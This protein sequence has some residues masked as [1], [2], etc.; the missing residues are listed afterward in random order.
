MEPRQQATLTY[1]ERARKAESA[2]AAE[3][4]FTTHK[5]RSAW[6]QAR[7][8]WP[9]REAPIDRLNLERARSVSELAP[10]P[11]AAQW[12]PVGPSDIGGRMTCA[13]C[14]PGAA[15]RLWAGAAGGGVWHSPDGGKTWQVLWDGEPSLNIG[16]L[17]LDPQS[18]DLIYCGTGEANLSADSHPGV[19]LF[20]SLNAGQ[21]WQVLAAADTVGLPRRIGAIAVD[22]FDSNH[23]LV[24]GVAHQAGDATGL[25]VSISGGL[26]WARVPLVGASP[27][28][29][30]D[31]HFHASRRNV[32]YV[33][34]SALGV[35]NGIWRS[36]D[37]RH[38]LAAAHRRPALARPDRPHIVGARTIR[39]RCSVCAN[40]HDWPAKPRAWPVPQR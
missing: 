10:P 34:I 30:H 28:R 5:R 38:Q 13:V 39:P 26:T 36:I 31:V 12:V 9:W 27:Y 20:R 4:S 40:E 29:C 24:G 21:S 14:H 2:D 3:E 17:A 37:G 22:P 33:T 11:G 7:E 6:F 32:I 19:G 23:L 15:E 35:K 25:F 1:V 16:A 18:P 8:S